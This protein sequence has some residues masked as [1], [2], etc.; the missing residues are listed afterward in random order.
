VALI[1]RGGG[2]TGLYCVVRNT[3]GHLIATH[4]KYSVSAS[5]LRA[6]SSGTITFH[7]PQTTR[8]YHWEAFSNTEWNIFPAAVILHISIF[9]AV[10]LQ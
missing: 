10:L 1:M 6:P 8:G 7:G 3:S 4:F 9:W 2:T 5:H